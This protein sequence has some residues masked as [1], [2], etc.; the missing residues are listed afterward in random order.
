M[1]VS[2]SALITS[3]RVLSAFAQA[4]QVCADARTMRDAA[5]ANMLTRLLNLSQRLVK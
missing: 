5:L 4:G 1:L 3:G 2:L